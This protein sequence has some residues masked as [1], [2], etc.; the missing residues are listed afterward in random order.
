M[1][2]P[3][4]EVELYQQMML[5]ALEQKDKIEAEKT[6]SELTGGTNPVKIVPAERVSLG[7][8]LRIS[9][10]ELFNGWD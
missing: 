9:L 5:S 1:L 6:G 4:T 8:R 3:L 2:N 7:T 10:R